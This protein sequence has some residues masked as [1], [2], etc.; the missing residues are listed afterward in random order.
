VFTMPTSDSVVFTPSIPY[1]P[2]ESVTVY[3]TPGLKDIGGESISNLTVFKFHVAAQQFENATLSYELQQLTTS[4]ATGSPRALLPGD[5]DNDGDLDLVGGDDNPGTLFWF[6]NLGSGNFSTG[7]VID[8]DNGYFDIKLTDFDDDGDLDLV[9]LDRSVAQGVYWYENNGS[10]AFTENVINTTNLGDNRSIS[11]A[12]FDHDGRLDVAVALFQNDG[13]NVFDREGNQIFSASN[14][15]DPIFIEEADMNGDGNMDFLTGNFGGSIALWTNTGT[16][17]FS[18]TTLHSVAQVRAVKPIDIDHD[19][20]LDVVYSAQSANQIGVLVNDGSGN[21]T[22]VQVGSVAAPHRVDVGDA[23]GDGDLDI[24]YS[25]VSGASNINFFYLENSG[26]LTLWVPRQ[27]ISTTSF[28][29]TFTQTIKY[30]DIDNDGDLDVLATDANSGFFIFENQIIDLNSAPVVNNPVS[31]QSMQEDSGSPIV[32]DISQVF[33]DPEG[34]AFTTTAESDNP[35]VTASISNNELTLDVN[36]PDFFGEVTITLTADDGNG[37]NSDVFT[38]IVNPVNDAPVF[39]LS[40][41]TLTVDEDFS[42]TETITVTQN[43]PANEAAPTYS[44]SPATVDFASISIDPAT[45]EVSISAVANG[46][47]TQEFTIT[48]DDGATVDNIATNSFVLTVNAVN[49]AP[50]VSGAVLLRRLSED[51]GTVEFLPLNSLFTDPDNDVLS[52]MISEDPSGSI[53]AQI[54]ANDVLEVTPA[55]NFNG[56]VNFTLTASDASESTTFD[57]SV[58]VTAVNDAPTFITSGNLGLQA[59]FTGTETVTVTP[60]EVPADELGQSVTYSLSPASVTFANVSINSMTGEVSVTAITGAEGSQ[61]FTI[62]ADDGEAEN[63][64]ATQNFTLTVINNLAPVVNPIADTAIE[65]DQSTTTIADVTT[66][67]SDPEGDPLTY[68][69][70]DNFN[71]EVSVVLNGSMLEV[72]PSLNYNGSGTI[73][74]TA[75]DPNQSTSTSFVLTVNAV[76]DAPVVANAIADQSVNEDALYEFE[77]PAN[78]F[79]DVESPNLTLSLENGPQWLSMDGTTISGTPTNADVGTVT[80]T[81]TASDGELS[82]SDE[83]QL[84]VINENDAPTVINSIA[85]QS[86]LEDG[87]TV[88]F[89]LLQVFEDIDGDQLS[90][91]VLSN[92]NTAIDATISGNTLTIDLLENLNGT[93]IVTFSA[94]DNIATT[95]T[96]VEITVAP[97]NDAPEFTLSETSLELLPEFET[98]SITVQPGEVPADEATQEVTYSLM[99]ASVDFADVSIDSSTGEI[100]ISPITGAFGEAAIS[101]IANDG[102]SENNTAEAT[103]SISVA[104]PVSVDDD[105]GL[106]IA[107]YPNPVK[108][109]L[110]LDLNGLIIERATILGLEGNEKLEVDLLT[111]RADMSTLPAG[112]G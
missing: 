71:G 72:T 4:V 67:F 37:T 92:T 33:T 34:D 77:I 84:T 12:D 28:G 69:V 35:A 58:V 21:F 53:M 7:K 51:E 24:L 13:V 83:F 26:S 87:E 102:Q 70:S 90:F 8:S 10:G 25:V 60:D 96:T 6:E 49:D 16:G 40:V 36:T 43:Q 100:T 5:L 81:V 30:A 31:D 78:T 73:T 110:L 9:T 19:G 46:F 38:L 54:N 41:S 88:T 105:A 14:A 93:G 52:F 27:L 22:N 109:I 112:F 11:I 29:G 107:V 111:G 63:N 89:D 82:V 98:V 44:I 39:E 56:A 23:D 57:I 97:V 103:F 108:D 15:N 85:A 95:S 42:A 74:L 64:I 1:F 99:P 91:S 32:I 76:N 101:V 79:A 86:L 75:S 62:T 68:S 48:A 106:G 66:V 50:E 65:E 80:V 18:E 61:E 94:T 17:S 59:D 2:N 55:E 3:L 104:N 47:G 45:G 20:D